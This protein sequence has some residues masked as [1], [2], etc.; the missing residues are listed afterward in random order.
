M[1][2]EERGMTV[3]FT[4]FD[5]VCVFLDRLDASVV[6]PGAWSQGQ[7]FYHLAASIEGTTDGDDGPF[8]RVA[9]LAST[10]QR[11]FVM[12][13]GLPRGVSIPEEVRSRV[14]PPADVDRAEQ[15]ER[16]R[17]A[18]EGFD[19]G[20]GT[21]MPHPALGPLTRDEWRRFHLR[22]CEHHLDGFAG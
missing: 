4:S 10:P 20:T 11:L 18:M 1:T 9:R 13:K 2:A 15:L 16:L 5:E 14:D 19:A 17:R 22:H 12:K 7:A 8:D 21:P 6:S 3:R